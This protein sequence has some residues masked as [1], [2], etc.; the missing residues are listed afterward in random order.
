VTA[1]SF[2]YEALPGRVVFGVGSVE[3]LGDEVERLGARRALLLAE[4]RDVARPT[5]LL[6]QLRAGTFT[7]V[8]QHVPVE[9]A[10]AARSLASKVDADCLVTVGG[11][12][13]TGFAKAVA[14]WSGLPIVAV[15]TTYAGSEM[16]PI[17]G[18]TADGRKRTGRDARVLPKV[19]LYDPA[20]TVTLPPEVTG[21]SGMNALAHCVEALYGPGANPIT[22]LLAVEGVRALASGLPVAVRS[23]EDLA[24][25]AEALRGAWLAGSGLAVAGVAIHHQAC[26]VLGGTFGLP[27]ADLNAVVLPHATAFVTPAVPDEMARVADALGAGDAAAGLYDLARKL[28][29]P[30]SL[31]ELGLAEADLDRAARMIAEHVAQRPRPSTYADVRALL[32]AAYAGERPREG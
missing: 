30:A 22:A 7:D 11:G 32:G 31:A 2:V 8:R 15:P 21:P 18:L 19:V 23:P 28:D 12:S 25:R 10:E 26:H 14:L 20:L 17:Y 13:A 9:V 5:E 6:G 4:E 24:G 1:A 3:R 29:A 27:H 16:T